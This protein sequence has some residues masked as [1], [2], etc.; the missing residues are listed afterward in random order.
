M[1]DVKIHEAAPDGPAAQI[2]RQAA[3][4]EKVTDASGRV[5]GIRRLNALENMRLASLAG[6]ADVQ[7]PVWMLYAMCAYSVIDIDGELI[8]KPGS[9]AQIE[10]LVHRLDSDGIGAIIQAVAPEMQDALG[11]AER[12]KN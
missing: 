6:P 8:A 5:I 2:V 3:E 7:N 11:E 10:A 4:V 12:A 1:A 9:K